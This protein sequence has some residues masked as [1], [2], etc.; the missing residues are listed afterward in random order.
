MTLD[1]E[2]VEDR[3]AG[4]AV[5]KGRLERGIGIGEQ[6]EEEEEEA[7]EEAEAESMADSRSPKR[8]ASIYCSRLLCQRNHDAVLS[9]FF[10]PGHSAISP[11]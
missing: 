1:D 6:E 3:A 9:Y 10:K 11:E 7:E 4:A 5:V 8:R 2:D